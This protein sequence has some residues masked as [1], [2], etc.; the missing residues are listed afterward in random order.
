MVL[1]F[2]PRGNLFQNRNNF[3]R[4]DAVNDIWPQILNGL[5]YLESRKVAHRDI[6]PENILLSQNNV[7]RITD[8]G[9]S[10][11]L[12][13]TQKC[14][15]V[16]GTLQYLSPQ[17]ASM[18]SYNPIKA[19]FWSAA[20]TLSFLVTKK[21]PFTAPEDALTIL[22][23]SIVNDE[24]DFNGC[25]DPKLTSLLGR[26]LEKNEDLRLTATECMQKY[27]CRE[28]KTATDSY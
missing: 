22:C 13:T 12:N 11:M 28:E 26:F 25:E 14:N 5:S 23:E 3:E 6:K 4:D 18:K 15:E 24:A 8:F 21:L 27:Y 16:V 17:E 7:P 2:A 1:E 9:C 10:M 19:D 20:V